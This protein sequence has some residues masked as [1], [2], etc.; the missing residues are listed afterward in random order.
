MVNSIDDGN[1]FI[2]LKGQRNSNPNE[3]I[4]KKDNA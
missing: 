1:A 3:I 4:L 2:D